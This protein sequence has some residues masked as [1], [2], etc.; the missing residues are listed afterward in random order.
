MEKKIVKK[1][2][3][4]RSIKLPIQTFKDTGQDNLVAQSKAVQKELNKL[5]NDLIEHYTNLNQR[6]TLLNASADDFDDDFS[7][8]QKDIQHQFDLVNRRFAKTES[9]KGFFGR[10]I[11]WITGK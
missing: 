6:I 9:K 11:A 3:K 10:F 4:K 8:Y 7:L 1:A 2:V 5:T